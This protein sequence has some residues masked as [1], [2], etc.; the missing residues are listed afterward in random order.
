MAKNE[1]KKKAGMTAT[2]TM[3]AASL[4]GGTNNNESENVPMSE[5]GAV[6]Q[7][8]AG[9]AKGESYFEGDF[10][11]TAHGARLDQALNRA[12]AER[13]AW[14]KK[15]RALEE[16]K[17]I[18]S[19]AHRR[20]LGKAQAL[21]SENATLNQSLKEQGKV[22]YEAQQELF[23]Q[24]E[25]L[26]QMNAEREKLLNKC[27]ELEEALRVTEA[28]LQHQAGENLKNAKKVKAQ[29][30]TLAITEASLQN[31]AGENLKKQAVIKQLKEEL[32]VTN[33][34]LLNQARQVLMKEKAVKKQEEE[35]KRLNEELAVTNASLLNQARQVLMKEKA[36]KKQE[37][38]IKRLNEELVVTN[39]ALKH[40]A[41][42]N[43][44]KGRE[45]KSLTDDLEKNKQALAR[46]L[47]EKQ[48]LTQK[49]DQ[50]ALQLKKAEQEALKRA[51][52]SI[53]Q[54]KEINALKLE[55]I[56]TNKKLVGSMK[57]QISLNQT[58]KEL[59]EQ[60]DIVSQAHQRRTVEAEQV[61]QENKGL[62]Q[63]L[64]KIKSENQLAT[65]EVPFNPFNY[66]NSGE[67]MGVV[68]YTQILE[69]GTE[70]IKG[71]ESCTIGQGGYSGCEISYASSGDAKAHAHF[72][73]NVH[74]TRASR[75]STVRGVNADGQF[76]KWERGEY[77]P[78]EYY[79]KV[80]RLGNGSKPITAVRVQEQSDGTYKYFSE[81]NKGVL[82]QA[83]DRLENGTK[84]TY[85]VSRYNRVSRSEGR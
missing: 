70:I 82:K 51:D 25:E 38:E 5:N 80:I 37:E 52:F 43:L 65:K 29:A 67:K 17:E 55:L 68:I 20:Q 11:E 75:T 8:V 21:E 79:E 35:I 60:L 2:L 63:Q 69:D 10:K 64:A 41:G 15:A 42:E 62:K 36:V 12:L 45:I 59:Q 47:E 7:T 73:D 18:T 57:E 81:S 53:E 48:L 28:S 71:V 6:T 34:S 78:D 74:V 54:A 77:N 23:Q 26:A 85:F 19:D 84:T 66:V 22:L 30:D 61:K 44:K 27:L 40:Q 16:E 46:S 56:N 31:Q 50:L 58:I 76:Q 24:K 39:A 32:A 72:R 49:A 13:D 4:F 9:T 83:M 3:A 1:V 33:A 14:E